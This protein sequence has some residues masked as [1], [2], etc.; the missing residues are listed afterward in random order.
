MHDMKLER[1][2]TIAF[3][4]LVSAAAAPAQETPPAP[5]GAAVRQRRKEMTP[6][7]RRRIQ[8]SYE[9]WKTLTP[10]QKALLKKR[11]DRLEEE[12]RATRKALT[13]DEGKRIDKQPV[14]RRRKELNDRTVKLMKERF[15][16]LPPDL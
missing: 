8:E 3:A 15:E 2:L 12:R 7:E 10:E 13:D 9:R 5:D 16:H 4:L 14:D 11:H 1:L 6:E